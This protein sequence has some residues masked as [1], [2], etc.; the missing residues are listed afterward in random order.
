MFGEAY[1]VTSYDSYPSHMHTLT[2]AVTPW[3]YVGPSVASVA[4][5]FA[6]GSADAAK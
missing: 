2:V 3:D 4:N 5:H 1:P 6:R